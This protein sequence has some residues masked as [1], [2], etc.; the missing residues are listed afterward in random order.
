MEEKE[1]IVHLNRKGYKIIE[2]EEYFCSGIDAILLASFARASKKS[3]T[4]DIGTGSCIIPILM[5]ARY[6]IDFLVAFEIQE[7]IFSLA[8]KSVELN[9]LEHKIR[10]INDDIQNIL[11]YYPSGFFD[12][13][14]SNPPYM[15][16]SG[17]ENE[18][19][20]KRIA[21]HE[22]TLNIFSLAKTAASALKFGGKIFLVHKPDRLVDIFCA[23]REN[24]IEPKKVTFVC[25][26][27]NRKANL[28]LVEGIKGGKPSLTVTENLIVYN[29]DGSY[30]K[31]LQ[32]IYNN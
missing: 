1:R 22:I 15:S 20:E 21:R 3:K 19:Q 10:V 14:T 31:E 24:N 28:V 25:S 27:V 5:E 7:K 23:L 17:F 6:N 30:T 29:S 18:G 2:N 16:N 12:V 32:N 9:S 26:Y 4:L 11:A 8:K 13:I